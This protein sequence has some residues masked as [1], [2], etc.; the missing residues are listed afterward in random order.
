MKKKTGSA[1]LALIVAL[2]MSFSVQAAETG[3][4]REYY[5]CNYFEGKDIDDLMSATEYLVE[6]IDALG[7]NSGNTYLWT[8]YKTNNDFDFIWFNEYENLNV[9]GRQADI[10]D[11]SDRGAAAQA[12]FDDIVLCTTGLV[13]HTQFWDGG[14]LQVTNPPA[15]VDSAACNLKPGK[16][17]AEVGQ[18][19]DH[20]VRVLEESGDFGAYTAFMQTPIISSA[21]RDVF[22]FGVY[23]DVSD[24]AAGGTIMQTTEDGNAVGAHFL[25]L[26]SCDTSLWNAQIIITGGN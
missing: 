4:V 12:R 19:V 20:Y 26:L 2:G 21:G 13:S 16:T 15:L 7:I 18:A 24:F 14:S 25:D 9:Y 1:I 10:Y 11:S 5:A 22:F 23:N 8:P 3:L 6:Q 17:M